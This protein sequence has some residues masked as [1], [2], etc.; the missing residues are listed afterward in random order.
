MSSV[1]ETELSFLANP[2]QV[3][4]RQKHDVF[5]NPINPYSPFRCVALPTE[6]L[7]YRKPKIIF[8]NCVLKVCWK[9]AAMKEPIRTAINAKRQLGLT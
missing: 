2:F 1:V 4:T 7:T 3:L 6:Q 9:S 5:N 8:C